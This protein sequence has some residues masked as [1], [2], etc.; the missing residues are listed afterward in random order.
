M[1]R[2][3][4]HDFY[5]F[6]ENQLLL[7][8]KK[9]RLE[10]RNMLNGDLIWQ[11]RFSGFSGAWAAVTSGPGR[12]PLLILP[13]ESGSIAF[14]DQNGDWLNSYRYDESTYPPFFYG[15]WFYIYSPHSIT[16]FKMRSLRGDL[17]AGS[18]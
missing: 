2:N 10:A 7:I 9:G 14:F 13:E 3:K 5:I 16:A 1:S 11:K 4:L 18:R 8:S 6:G 15:E 12:H 17:N